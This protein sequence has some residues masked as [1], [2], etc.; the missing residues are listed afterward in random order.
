LLCLDFHCCHDSSETWL[1]VGTASGCSCM[2]ETVLEGV[3]CSGVPTELNCC[4]TQSHTC[5]IGGV[6]VVAGRMKMEMVQ[7]TSH[8]CY[9]Q[10]HTTDS[11]MTVVGGMDDNGTCPLT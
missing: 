10:V 2:G 8:H 11:L 9:G 3:H 6:L 7:M 1:P 5:H 4:C